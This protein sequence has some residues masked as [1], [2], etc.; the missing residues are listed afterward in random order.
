MT[1]HPRTR[2]C[3]IYTRKSSEEGLE[4]SFNSLDAQRAGGEAFIL[5]Q[6]GEGWVCLPD[7]YDDGAYSGGNMDRPALT[8]LLADIAAGL[9]DIV[10][11]YKTDRLTR[12]IRDFSKIMEVFDAHEVS[13]VAVTQSFNTSTSMGRLTLHM[14]LSFAQFERE[15]ASER[16]RDKIALQRQ[17]GQ[18]TGGRPM[19]GYDIT[20][21]G[22]VVNPVEAG[23]VRDIFRWYL[24]VKSLTKVLER[25]A[26]KGI[27]NKRWTSKAGT[28][29][30]GIPFAKSTLSQLLSAIIYKGLVP[31]KAAS[32]PGL[33]QAI[34]DEDVFQRVQELL[35]ENARC[36]PSAIRNRHHGLLKGLITCACCGKAM[37][38]TF[39]TKGST[40]H[41]YYACNSRIGVQAKK[42]KG[43]SLPAGQ[44]EDFVLEKVRHRFS[45]PEMVSRVLDLVREQSHERRRDLEAQRTLLVAEIESAQAILNLGPHADAADRHEH[46]SRTLAGVERQLQD[47]GSTLVD[48]ATV[49]HGL[50]EFTPIWVSL[51]P[52]ERASLLATVVGGVTWNAAQGEIAI[53]TREEAAPAEIPA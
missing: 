24:E 19:L 2:R 52:N 39:T 45:E 12:S 50:T 32:Y 43:G 26:A 1:E 23:T 51:S 40:T 42:C 53:T 27:T 25:L 37:V 4:Q 47:I 44:V 30:G 6:K 18:W 7:R 36:G 11:V 34:I 41:R 38:H 9:I 10:V 49:E 21:T 8:R 5:S 29:Q 33:H 35:A 22:L 13:L 15:L 17:R 20:P 16:T 28:P 14:L 3:A 31:H 48:R 46:A